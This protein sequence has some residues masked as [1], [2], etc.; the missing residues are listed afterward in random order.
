M[1]GLEF[2]ELDAVLAGL[3]DLF[4]PL[5]NA[6]GEPQGSH[7]MRTPASVFGPSAASQR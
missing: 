4:N 1:R 7:R 6:T 3:P 2:S 5:A